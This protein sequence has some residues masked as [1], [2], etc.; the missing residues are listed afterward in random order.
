[1]K[2]ERV[3]GVKEVG[4]ETGSRKLDMK[5]I[6]EIG[7]KEPI[8]AGADSESMALRIGHALVPSWLAYTHAPLSR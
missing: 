2:E 7:L 8:R 5:G 1:M 6:W 4:N 3:Y